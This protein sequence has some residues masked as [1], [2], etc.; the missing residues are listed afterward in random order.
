MAYPLGSGLELVP[1]ANPVSSSPIA[2][3]IATTP[4]GL[5]FNFILL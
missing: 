4:S 5:V 3:D 2:D 1:D